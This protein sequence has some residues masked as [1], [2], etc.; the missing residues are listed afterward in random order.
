MQSL[1]LPQRLQQFVNDKYDSV[2]IICLETMYMPHP[3]LQQESNGWTCPVCS[4][5]NERDNLLCN[6]CGF[7]R[8]LDF[9]MDDELPEDSGPDEP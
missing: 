9:P 1:W 7:V 2:L 6:A 5:H 4:A 3:D 8:D